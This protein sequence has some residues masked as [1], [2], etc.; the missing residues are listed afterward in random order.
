V[1]DAQE[2]I[3]AQGL[4]MLIGQ[5]YSLGLTGAVTLSLARLERVVWQTLLGQS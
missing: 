5:T 3:S 1:T 4:L 2:G